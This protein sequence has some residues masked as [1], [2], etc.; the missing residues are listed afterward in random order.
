MTYPL[1][2]IPDY[3]VIVVGGG[4]A[5]ATCARFLGEK[6]ARVLLVDKASFPRDKVCGDAISSKALKVV[7]RLGVLGKLE[8]LPHSTI[9]GITFSSPE[10]KT[11]NVRIQGDKPN[12]KG[13]CIRRTAFDNLLFEHASKVCEFREKTQVVGMRRENNRAYVK[14]A[15]LSTKET[16]EVSCSVVVG[17][18]GATS[19][20]ANSLNVNELP[21]QHGCVAVRAYVS[22]VEGLT[23]NIEI[24]FMDEIIPGYFW[25]FPLENGM[26]NVGLGMILSE[27][28]YKHTNLVHALESIISTSRF[29]SR[30]AKAK[31][32]S[33]IMGW[34]LP[35]GSHRR[36]IAHAHAVL[37]GDAAALV[38]PFTGEGIGNAMVSGQLAAET[39]LDALEKNDFSEQCLS[40][41]ETKVWKTLGLD[42]ESSTKLQRWVRFKPLLNM[43]FAKASTNPKVA[44][45]LSA[46]L[47]DENPKKD[48]AN[49]L[50]I[51]KLLLS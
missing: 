22:N 17:A 26:V 15:D 51:L 12:Q 49:P 46:A 31:M 19:E 35:F 3:D 40:A 24:H 29:S 25:I 21:S 48:L 23:D 44:A 7:E 38:D 36:K 8:T 33:P 16:K 37:I 39:I 27:M 43:C 47:F 42:L 34:T 6:N 32:E 13:Y 2:S 28:H 9:Q 20:I 30:F 18:D 14:L 45:A 41:Y 10:G 1:S 4:P 50:N 5:G 11:F